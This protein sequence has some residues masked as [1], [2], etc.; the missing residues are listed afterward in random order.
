MTHSHEQVNSQD[1]LITENV[2]NFLKWV[3][4]DPNR[5][6]LK[7]TPRR[8]LKMYKEFFSGYQLNSDEVLS[9]M[10]EEIE[11]YEGI[12]ALR[13]IEFISHCEH[14][15]LPFVGNISISYMPYKRVIGISKLARVVDI[16]AKRLQLQEKLTRQI[17]TSIFNVLKPYGVAVKIDAK[18]FCLNYR[19]AS[20]SATIMHTCEYLGEQ[21]HKAD[22]FN[23]L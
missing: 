18:H 5:E 4:E 15:L 10:F 1:S 23:A 3:G 21:R 14:H 20:K 8:V 6:G 13:N 11:G 22:I 12:V 17:T 7:E 19:G 9:K 2:K 16:F